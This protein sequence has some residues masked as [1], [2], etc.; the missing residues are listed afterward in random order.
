MIWAYIW[1]GFCVFIL[2]LIFYFA[3]KYAQEDNHGDY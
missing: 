3:C 1:T 2:V